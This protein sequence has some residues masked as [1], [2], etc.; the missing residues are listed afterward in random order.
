MK[1]PNIKKNEGLI[2][3][4]NFN[5][6][7][8]KFK[9]IF[10]LFILICNLI[11]GKNK[12]NHYKICLCAIA[13]NENLYARE[14]VEHYKKIGYDKIFIYD[15]NE[16][17]GE[18]FEEVIF[19]Y[20]QNGFVQIIDIRGLHHIP[21]T[22]AYIDCYKMNHN[23]YDWLSFFDLDEFLEI[24]KRYKSIHDFIN[25]KI[26]RYC[27]NIKINWLFYINDSSINY[28]NKPLQERFKT[29]LFNLSSNA[30]IKSTVR[31]NLPTNYW[32]TMQ[33][34]H[35]S[36]LNYKCCTSS[37]KK[38]RFDT[39]FQIPPDYKNAK[40]KHYHFK[41]F[42][43]YCL[44]IKRG[45]ADLTENLNKNYIKEKVQQLYT[46]NKDNYE[47]LKILNKIF[48]YSFYFAL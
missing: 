4:Y 16:K 37:G 2:I 28:E 17:E 21:Q 12:K 30:H 27:K 34:P 33:T 9:S 10:E 15:N 8:Q 25:D 14:F 3:F 6:F 45:R 44:K 41:S 23:F 46:K 43:E 7:N 18:H 13:K 39:P 1:N 40:L 36:D 48:N 35:T 5:K 38:I 32:K 19:D 42:E 24:D 26:F 29:P 31:G 22:K 11:I 20:I 47:K